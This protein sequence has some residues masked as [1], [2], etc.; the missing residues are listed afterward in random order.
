MDQK[1]ANAH[2]IARHL[3]AIANLLQ[4]DPEPLTGEALAVLEAVEGNIQLVAGPTAG[5]DL[6]L[7]AEALEATAPFIP[8]TNEERGEL[9]ADLVDE[10]SDYSRKEN[11]ESICGDWTDAEWRMEWDDREAQ[12]LEDEAEDA[13]E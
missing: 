11:A 10:V 1:L 13:G 9:F 4:S 5:L 6:N 2:L 3:K 12:R 8:L 7:V